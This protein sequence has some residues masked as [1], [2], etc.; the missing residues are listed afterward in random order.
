MCYSVGD[1]CLEL[2]EEVPGSVWVRNEHSNLHHIGFWSEGLVDVSAG[3]AGGGCPM[4]LCGR[5][6]ED[7]PVSFAYHRDDAA[8]RASRSSSTRP[9]ATPWRSCSSPIPR[10]AR[11][12]VGLVLRPMEIGDLSLVS[13]WLSAPHVARWWLAGSSVERELDDL[14]QSVT[15]MQP[16]HAAPRAQRRRARR[17]VPVVPVLARARLGR[18]RR[19]GTAETSG[20]TTPSGRRRKSAEAWGPRWSRAL[21]ELVQTVHPGCGVIAGPDE[22]NAASRRVLEK[23]GFELVRVAALPSEATDDPVAIYRMSPRAPRDLIPT[24]RGGSRR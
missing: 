21:V 17:V 22:R 20:S 2:I 19:R 10:E 12:G 6:G 24:R 15:G 8:R 4:Q 13:R 18:R 5:A 14:R 3:L 7:A 1:P 23:N 9:C 16:V 11:G